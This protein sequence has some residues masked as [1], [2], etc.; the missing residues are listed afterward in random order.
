MI[1]AII[2]TLNEEEQ[3]AETIVCL[4]NQTI[5]IDEI[6]VVD[7]GSSDATVEIA[8]NMGCI[9]L[10]GEKN[11]GYNWEMGTQAA[12][13]NIILSIDADTWLPHDWVERALAWFET[14]ENV[15]AVVGAL[16]PKNPTPDN[17]WFCERRNEMDQTMQRSACVIFIRPE[18]PVWCW[19]NL[20]HSWGEFSHLKENLADG[21]TVYDMELIA[22][23]DIPPDQPILLR[24]ALAV[25]F[26][27]FFLSLLFI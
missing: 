25:P 9:V 1:T 22:W 4:R 21:I 17:I 15:M 20:C 8:Q 2:P 11:I 27:A 12:R 10:R 14:D 3:I 6:I 16:A 7:S 24:R 18:G 26:Y 13:N 19:N 5:P 23:T